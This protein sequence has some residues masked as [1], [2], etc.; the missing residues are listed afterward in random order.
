MSEGIKWNDWKTKPTCRPRIAARPSSSRAVISTPAISTRPVLGESSPAS[1]ANKRGLTGAGSADDG[2]S[3]AGSHNQADIGENGQRALPGSQRFSTHSW[4]RERFDLA[5]GA[6][7]KR[8]FVLLILVW[9]ALPA[10]AE[11]PVILVFGDSISAGYGLRRVEARLGGAAA[12]EAQG[13]RVRLPGRQCQ[14]QRRNDRRGARASAAR[15]EPAPP[16]DR[17][18]RIGRQ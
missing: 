7:V 10:S 18:S 4:L 11:T 5:S 15:A 8:L 17:D 16:A 13:S 12:G 9:A 1:S 2:E 3:L 6:P 14:R